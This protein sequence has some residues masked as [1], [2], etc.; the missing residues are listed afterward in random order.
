M[1]I[2]ASSN[3]KLVSSAPLDNPTQSA[4]PQLLEWL[5]CAAIMR[6]F[7]GCHLALTVLVT[8]SHAYQVKLPF[9]I[10]LDF[11]L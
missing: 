9:R 5:K 2:E 6:G 3:M 4:S 11:A 10:H 1:C 7:P 8:A